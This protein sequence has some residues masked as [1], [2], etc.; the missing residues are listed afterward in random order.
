MCVYLR[1]PPPHRTKQDAGPDIVVATPAKAVAHVTAKVRLVCGQMYVCLCMPLCEHST[2]SERAAW[3]VIQIRHQRLCV[4]CVLS[5]LLQCVEGC[6]CSA[7]SCPLLL[8]LLSFLQ[9][10]QLKSSLEVL[11]VDEADLTFS[12]G[13]EE[14]MRR[15]LPHLPRI[16]QAI[17]MSATLSADVVTLKKLVLHNPVSGRC[18]YVCVCEDAG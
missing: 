4:W 5:D 12:Y 7:L 8:R 2:C 13:F 1:P 15:L 3:G 6:V 18:V 16:H 14:D 17:L 9:S 10:L 11:V